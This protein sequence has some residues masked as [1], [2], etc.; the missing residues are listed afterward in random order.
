MQE[1]D[2]YWK[3]EERGHPS[4]HVLFLDV[5]AVREHILKVVGDL[6]ELTKC[7]DQNYQWQGMVGTSRHLL[8]GECMGKMV[9][10][11][12]MWQRMKTDNLWLR[13]Y[14]S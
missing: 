2:P 1:R 10:K 11:G 7:F 3:T 9:N 5:Y 6:S 14:S 4:L 13:T 12:L 8:G